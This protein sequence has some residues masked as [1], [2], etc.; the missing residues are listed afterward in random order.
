MIQEMLIFEEA[1]E[2]ASFF[3]PGRDA[4]PCFVMFL[5]GCSI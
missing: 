1:S 2:L 5:A 3:V 4:V